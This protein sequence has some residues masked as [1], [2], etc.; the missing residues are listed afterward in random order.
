[1]CVSFLCDCESS[2]TIRQKA[3]EERQLATRTHFFQK[4]IKKLKE[5][6]ESC[7]TQTDAFREAA[8]RGGATGPLPFASEELIKSLH[9][10][11]EEMTQ[12]FTQAQHSVEHLDAE[13]QHQRDMHEIVLSSQDAVTTLL[14]TC[15]EDVKVKYAA[16]LSDSSEPIAL[17][18]LNAV[19]RDRVTTRIL[20]RLQMFQNSHQ[21]RTPMSL[22]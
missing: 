13:F 3:E 22:F 18:D 2:E 12:A 5:K 17:E 6:I 1:M 8:Q 19:Q 20:Q 21:V 7:T 15:L 16:E 4:L 11:Y 10:R 14:L 9:A